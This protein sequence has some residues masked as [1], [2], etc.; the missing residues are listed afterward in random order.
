MD[1]IAID[2]VKFEA[3]QDQLESVLEKSFRE[4][5][6]EEQLVKPKGSVIIDNRDQKLYSPT[7]GPL[8]YCYSYFYPYQ[9]FVIFTQ[10]SSFVKSLKT[11]S[12]ID[13]KPLALILPR[14]ALA[15]Q[16]QLNPNP[17]PANHMSL[18]SQYSQPF[19]NQ[20]YL[21]TSQ[22]TLIFVDT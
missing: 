11:L 1:R 16:P 20:T 21:S 5:I 7:K 4:L 18:T 2:I 6:Y 13:S 14:P 15:S 9:F 17:I 3:R 12:T 8:E 22:I 19:Y 10:S